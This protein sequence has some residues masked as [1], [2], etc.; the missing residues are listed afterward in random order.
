[1]VVFFGNSFGQ[2]GEVVGR[3]GVAYAAWLDHIARG[4]AIV[5]QPVLPAAQATRPQSWSAGLAAALRQALTELERDDTLLPAA[6][7]DIERLV[8]VGHGQGA[9]I[10]ANL[11]GEWFERR[12]PAPRALLLLMPQDPAGILNAASLAAI[13]RDTQTLVV[14]ADRGGSYDDPAEIRLW[15]GTAQIP[16]TWRNRLVITGDTY[17]DPALVVDMRAPLTGGPDGAIDALDWYGSWKWLDGL[18]ACAWSGLDCA[19]ALGGTPRQTSL[20]SWSD[21]Q[22]VNPA[23]LSD[24][25]VRPRRWLGYLPAVSR[26]Y[27]PPR[28]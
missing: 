26:D 23:R 6:R 18:T 14:T 7:P 5:I 12:L 20:G 28:R 11:A 25:L 8:M 24:E 1:V 4:G 17:G 3:D 16:S 13:P 15:D 22:P 21:G 19:Y 9:V 10:A 27:R 2:W